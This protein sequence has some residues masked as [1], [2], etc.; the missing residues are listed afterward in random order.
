MKNKSELIKA[1]RRLYCM[2][3]RKPD[4]KLTGAEMGLR[5]YFAQDEDTR[6]ILRGFVLSNLL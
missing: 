3:L 2:L 5:L 4:D 6:P 1:K